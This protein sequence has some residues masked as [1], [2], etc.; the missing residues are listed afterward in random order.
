VAHVDVCVQAAFVVEGEVDPIIRAV[1]RCR[2]WLLPHSRPRLTF[3]D[4]TPV[5]RQEHQ[6]KDIRREVGTRVDKCSVR[7]CDAW[8]ERV[9][10]AFQVHWYGCCVTGCNTVLLALLI[11]W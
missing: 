10:E 5:H 4:V 7:G 3:V 1:R 11:L 8:T 6:R 9:K 2:P